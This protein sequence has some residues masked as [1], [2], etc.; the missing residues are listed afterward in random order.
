M[1]KGDR[2]ECSRI[3]RKKGRGEG[4]KISLRKEEMVIRKKGGGLR[5]GIE[6][7]IKKKGRQREE[8]GGGGGENK[9]YSH[10]RPFPPCYKSPLHFPFSICFGVL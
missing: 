5:E 4:K 1:K 8:E 10:K 2:E 3:T 6:G 7:R 9:N